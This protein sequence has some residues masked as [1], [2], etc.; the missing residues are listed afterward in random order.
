MLKM[1]NLKKL[2]SLEFEDDYD[3]I[4]ATIEEAVS[5]LCQFK[6][7]FTISD[8]ILEDPVEL[9]T[10]LLSEYQEPSYNLDWS[11][12][13]QGTPIKVLD[14]DGEWLDAIFICNYNGYIMAQ[15]EPTYY[16]D[17]PDDEIIAVYNFK[18]GKLIE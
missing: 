8:E 6:L 15:C 13:E 18:R 7:G 1:T 12:V 11:K 16:G 9:Y 17:N 14:D 3:Y 5:D 2:I 4:N 10:W